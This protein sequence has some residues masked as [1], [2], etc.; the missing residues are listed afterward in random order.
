MIMTM[1]PSCARTSTLTSCSTWYNE[2]NFD[3]K[4]AE[5]AAAS[6]LFFALYA[7]KEE[8]KSFFTSF[9]FLLLLLITSYGC[10][11]TPDAFFS[12]HS[13]FFGVHHKLLLSLP[14]TGWSRSFLLTYHELLKMFWKTKRHREK[15][16]KPVQFCLSLDEKQMICLC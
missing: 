3:G 2:L 4:Q 8:I 9:P 12:L 11:R 15:K 10:L 1:F 14:P 5:T 7:V 13:T 16:R 6:F